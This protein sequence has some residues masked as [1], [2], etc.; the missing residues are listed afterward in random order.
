MHRYFIRVDART[1]EMVGRL[2]R[3]AIDDAK[4][5]LDEEGWNADTGAWERMEGA[6]IMDRLI[7]GD[8]LFDEITVAQA[9]ELTPE[10]FAS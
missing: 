7:Q 1:G 5:T 8:P 2:L 10:A 6:P 4:H 9:R 3:L